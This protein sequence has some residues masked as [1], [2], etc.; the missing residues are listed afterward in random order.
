MQ[1]RSE[2]RPQA[3]RG[4]TTRLRSHKRPSEYYAVRIRGK[5]IKTVSCPQSI[6]QSVCPRGRAHAAAAKPRSGGRCASSAAYYTR[7]AVN[8]DP[9]RIGPTY[10]LSPATCQ[11]N[12]S[13]LERTSTRPLGSVADADERC[14]AVGR[15]H[16]NRR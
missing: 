11:L 8:S 10:L 13:R 5:H 9:T 3:A 6:S 7:A 2:R 15:G 4:R 12:S 1:K 16:S 14:D